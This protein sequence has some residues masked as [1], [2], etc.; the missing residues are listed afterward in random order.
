MDP[1]GTIVFTTV[2]RPQYGFDLFSL[3]LCPSTTLNSPEHR[4]TD[5][6]S[7]NFNAQFV[8]DDQTLVF[9]SE[10][11]GSPRIYLSRPGVGTYPAYTSVGPIFG[12]VKATVQIARME[13]DPVDLDGDCED[14]KCEMK[15]LTREE[16]GNNAFPSCSPDGKFIVFRSGR[17]GH[18]NL[19]IVDAVDGELN[20]G[21]RQL[22]EGPWIDTMPHWSPNGDLIA[23]SSNRHN[24]NNVDAFSIFVIKPDGSGLRRI[25]VAGLEG[26]SD[27]DRERI[28]H[29]CFSKD[30]KWLVFTSNLGGVTAEPVSLPN[31]FQPYGDLYVV[32]V[33]GS[34][35]R[36]LTWNGYENGTPAWHPNDDHALDMGHIRLGSEVG[37]DM[38]KGEFDDPLWISCNM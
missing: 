24:P 2:G 25:H 12:S 33:D 22:T 38:L 1:A 3:E 37:G 32:R 30:G 10:R 29:V 14:I 21:L 16:T 19:Y 11:T 17:S 15:I 18:K 9:I 28:N 31:S 27:V 6:I 35:L 26:T 23:F 20:G 13:F 36:R 4:L 34:Q 5:G 7:I 8:D